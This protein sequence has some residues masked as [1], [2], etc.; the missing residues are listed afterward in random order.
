MYL[1]S[2]DKFRGDMIRDPDP[3]NDY[4]S[5]Y[6]TTTTTT[7]TEQ[8]LIEEAAAAATMAIEFEMVKMG[9]ANF[10]SAVKPLLADLI[11]EDSVWDVSEFES[12]RDALR[13]LEIELNF[14]YE[15]LFTKVAVVHSSWGRFGHGFA[16]LAVLL[17]FL[18]FHV[19]SP[20]GDVI[21]IDVTYALLYGALALDVVAFVMSILSDW[22]VVLGTSQNVM[23]RWFS[24]RVHVKILRKSDIMYR[25]REVDSDKQTELA[26]PILFRRWNRSVSGFNLMDFSIRKEDSGTL[27]SIESFVNEWR[28][29]SRKAL[30]LELWEFIYLELG[31]KSRLQC[32]NDAERVRKTCCARGE[33]ILE[34]NQK[35]LCGID[36]M[37][38]VLGVPYDESLLLWHIATEFLYNDSTSKGRVMKREFSKALSDYMLYLLIM[39]PSMV[40]TVSGIGK[41]RFEDTCAQV[42][43]FMKRSR[44][45]EKL[46][47]R[48]LETTLSPSMTKREEVSHGC[49]KIL[50]MCG[51]HS[52]NLWKHKST[53]VL[54]SAI[55]LARELQ[56]IV[57]EREMWNIIA[58]MWVELLSYAA[59]NCEKSAHIQQLSNGGELVT[60]VWLMMAH[61]GLSMQFQY[62]AGALLRA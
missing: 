22:V 41:I 30:T 10:N 59:I 49:K 47:A 44:R 50:D 11:L 18:I 57:N 13:V 43:M 21:D 5:E 34:I 17:A 55:E 6:E 62:K 37:D 1:A 28:F 53:T 9:Y 51:D 29:K 45:H 4:D 32:R 61:Y 20:G 8:P 7:T 12:A 27:N 46:L 2:K 36:L 31:S 19:R 52:S 38:Y 25:V 15:V 42:R 3:G 23:A 33:V 56:K 39:Q 16:F 26:R 60:Y 54:N 58:K 14:A 35:Y 24:D 48:L 40:A